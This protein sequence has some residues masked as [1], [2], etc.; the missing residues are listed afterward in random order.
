M[1]QLGYDEEDAFNALKQL[2]AWNLAEPE[3]LVIEELNPEDPVQVHASGFM[4]LRYLAQQPEYIV[5]TSADMHYSSYETSSTIAAI[6]NSAGRSEPGFKNRQKI[7]EMSLAYMR[8]E[9]DR[10]VR[11]HA[12]YED[13]GYGGKHLVQSMDIALRRLTG[14]TQSTHAPVRSRPPRR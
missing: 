1:T 8:A 6:W 9:Y 4:H 5:G 14:Q 7:L 11:R 13:L 3:S 2:V 12:F 10:R